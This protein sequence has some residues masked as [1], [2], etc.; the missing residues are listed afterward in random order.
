MFWAEAG[1][2]AL[3]EAKEHEKQ[4][5]SSAEVPSSTSNVT[6]KNPTTSVSSSMSQV[7]IRLK[8]EGCFCKKTTGKESSIQRCHK[9]AFCIVPIGYKI[10][11]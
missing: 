7:I 3:T 11:I 5:S 4:N 8:S 10:Q 9:L 1:K 2:L 6:E